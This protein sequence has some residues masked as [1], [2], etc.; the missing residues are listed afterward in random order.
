M[1]ASLFEV[2][3]VQQTAI[4]Y[5]PRQLKLEQ[6]AEL[7]S[8]LSQI[9]SDPEIRSLI[10]TGQEDEFMSGIAPS[11]F[12]KMEAH[13]LQAFLNYVQGLISF[14]ENFSKPVIAAVNGLASGIGMELALACHVVLAVE[15]A[16]FVL[17]ELELGY[18][19]LGGGIQRLLRG[20]G[21]H[22]TLEI[23]LGG[24]PLTAHDAYEWGLL[25]HLFEAQE[26]IEK[27]QEMAMLFNSKSPLAVQQALKSVQ[28]GQEMGLQQSLELESHLNSICWQSND[29]QE[30]V[31]AYLEQRPPLFRGR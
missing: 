10:L 29:F 7:E 17:P 16:R 11:S 15:N 14:V 18:L 8:R 2:Q 12:K 31:Q 26:L 24:Y 22:R 25:N 13:H 3:I 4:L 23:T 28:T 9:E 30:G 19:P 27:A 21:R 1:Q 20:L 5:L 6:C